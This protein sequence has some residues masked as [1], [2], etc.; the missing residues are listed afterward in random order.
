MGNLN[1]IKDL[2]SQLSDDKSRAKALSRLFQLVDNDSFSEIGVYAEGSNILTGSGTIDGRIVY[3]YCQYGSVSLTQAKKL[4]NI[5]RLALTMG[6]PVVGLLD[7][8]GMELENAVETL[9]A[10][11]I[12]YKIM[13]DASGVIPQISIV[14]GD[15]MGTASITCG[16]SDYVSV[17]NDAKIF[18]RSPNS[19][20]EVKQFK[21]GVL[22][23]G[24]Y[25]YDNTGVA[26]FS[27][28]S[29]AEC[30]NSVKAMLSYL[31]GNNLED[32][33]IIV[34]NDDAFRQDNELNAISPDDIYKIIETISDNRDFLEIKKGY[35]KEII[36]GFSRFDGFSTGIIANN[37]PLSSAAIK[38]AVKFI[39]F[40]DAF[41]IP[42]V[43]LTNVTAYGESFSDELSVISDSASLIYAFS[44]SS[45]PK[46]N[47]IVNNSAGS[48]YMV[49]NSKYSGADILYAWENSNISLFDP[50]SA[51]KVF[52]DSPNLLADALKKGFIDDIIEPSETRR[53]IIAAV[54]ILFTKRV[55]KHPKKHG[56]I[57]F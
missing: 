44:N 46:I 29:E 21:E 35:A 47:I 2:K 12:I 28:E 22:F 15:C 36:T 48:P 55:F 34:G 19:F 6:A 39:S 7:S 41:N 52:S 32:T 31:P 9:E 37:G 18:M 10:Y 23:S 4:E 53:K 27:G 11:G 5:Y 33:P 14:L 17:K 25:H 56:S 42:I 13:S 3:V 26:D 24:K 54:E 20:K 43:T 30:I 50:A 16:L 40:C 57:V 38:K 49:M 51:E 8:N 45:V 1:T